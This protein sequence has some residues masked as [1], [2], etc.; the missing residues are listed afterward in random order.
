[1]QE[2]PSEKAMDHRYLFIGFDCRRVL[3]GDPAEKHSA[4]DIGCNDCNDNGCGRIDNGSD[5]SHDRDHSE[6]NR[7]TF[8]NNGSRSESDADQYGVHVFKLC[9]YGDV[10]PVERMGRI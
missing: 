3:Y 10:R 2:V 9:Q 4:A 7:C 5:T 6:P 1:M 8:G